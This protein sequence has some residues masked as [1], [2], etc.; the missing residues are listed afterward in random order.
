MARASTKVGDVFSVKL[1]STH[2]KY[3]Q[4]IVS[5]L[6]QL[7][8]D[9]IRAFKTTYPN[10]TKPSIEEIVKDEIDFY[11]HCVTKLGIKMGLWEK[12]GNSREI[13]DVSNVLFRGTSDSGR[14]LGEPPIEISN[15]WYVWR[16]NDKDFQQVGK[17]IGDYTRAEI[18]LVVN[19]YDIVER[20]KTGKY[21]F[22]YPGY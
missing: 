15:K 7:N 18:G 13:G 20:M 11:A 8:S 16:V 14:K 9:V 10:D 22:V 19:P 17:L 1:D 12:V 2:K 21:G 3:M 6:M 4:Y 5:D